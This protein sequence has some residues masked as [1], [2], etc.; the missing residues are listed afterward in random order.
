MIS[1]KMLQG[2]LVIGALLLLIAALVGAYKLV[3]GNGYD[4]GKAEAESAAK[5]RINAELT[6]ANAKILELTARAVKAEREAAA[7]ITASN[8]Q[9]RKDDA[10]ADQKRDAAV[11]VV[12]GGLAGMCKQFNPAATLKADSGPAGAAPATA[13]GADGAGAGGLF[14]VV[15]G[16]LSAEAIR[17]DRIARKLTQAQAV[18][19]VYLAT[20]NAAEP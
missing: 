9:R 7:R 6:E 2:L 14:E 12:R 5:D 11:D 8:D 17:A 1:S 16:F 19:R 15:G 13:S 20:C 3:D 10:E 18:I 4:R